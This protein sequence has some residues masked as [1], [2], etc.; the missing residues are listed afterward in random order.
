[1]GRSYTAKSFCVTSLDKSGMFAGL[2]I[3]FHI[4]CVLLHL[5]TDSEIK[6]IPNVAIIS[7]HVLIVPHYNTN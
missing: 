6:Q 3:Q 7:T 5:G 1:M 4:H 2:L